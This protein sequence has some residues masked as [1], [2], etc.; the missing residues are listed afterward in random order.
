MH[1]CLYLKISFRMYFSQVIFFLL[2]KCSPL[3]CI[4]INYP[5]FEN[6][7]VPHC[8]LSI[9]N[10]LLM[11]NYIILKFKSCFLFYGICSYSVCEG[12]LSFSDNQISALDMILKPIVINSG[13][14][15]II[16][17]Y[18]EHRMSVIK[19]SIISNFPG[20]ITIM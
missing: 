7:I 3:G 1:C 2:N 19:Y 5:K 4:S 12:L 6:Y 17:L 15:E 16:R 18:L 20:N 8:Q 10:H 11:F 14:I 13:E 9:A